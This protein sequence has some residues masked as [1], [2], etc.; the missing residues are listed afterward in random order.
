MTKQPYLPPIDAL[1]TLGPSPGYEREDEADDSDAALDEHA[2]SCGCESCDHDAAIDEP[3]A[4]S[5]DAIHSDDGSDLDLPPGAPALT[6]EHIAEL[7]RMA[8]DGALLAA[9]DERAWAP[10]H[11][12]R[13]L[14]ALCENADKP[15]A[16]CVVPPLVET[17][18][19]LDRLSDDFGLEEL[20]YV[21][22]RIGPA[23]L[24]YI[25][26]F[27]RDQRRRFGAR[28]YAVQA[29]EL[30]AKA[31]P[32]TR[33]AVRHALR[34]VL[35]LARFNDPALNGSAIAAMIELNDVDSLPM[36]RKAFEDGRVDEFGCG[37][38]EDVEE[39][40]RQS[41]AERL[42]KMAQRMVELEKNPPTDIE[43]LARLAAMA[44]SRRK[45]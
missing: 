21:F 22:E 29:L 23:A 4:P 42:A 8:T 36:I 18:D 14:A 10:V 41:K 1:L 25:A 16:A 15:T 13:M 27:Y 9:R 17:L 26:T 44:E 20:P 6:A 38:L 5:P 2:E 3:D 34:Q 40:I 32:S 45:R 39:A 28:L 31:H 37:S 19:R 7:V 12:W 24:P 33:D 35:A 43:L 30:I 11:A